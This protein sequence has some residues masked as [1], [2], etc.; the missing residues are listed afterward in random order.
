MSTC[1]S[2]RLA[3][4]VSSLDQLGAP[5]PPSSPELTVDQSNKS[6][7]FRRT[8]STFSTFSTFTPVHKPSSRSTT[9]QSAI[10]ALPASPS[11]ADLH[12]A[13]RV[14]QSHDH[15]G[16]VQ[17]QQEESGQNEQLLEWTLLARLVLA[18]Y[19][20]R[21]DELVRSAGEWEDEIDWWKRLDG[22]GRWAWDGIGG[23]FVQSK[24]SWHCSSFL[25]QGLT[26]SSPSAALPHRLV[27]ASVGLYQ[28][29]DTFSYRSLTPT[30]LL[31]SLFPTT[32]IPRS[33]QY[34]FNPKVVLRM[35]RL[36][37]RARIQELETGR[38]DRVKKL[39][40]VIVDAPWFGKAEG[41][42]DA[43]KLGKELG[44]IIALLQES[45]ET[46]G[47]RHVSLPAPDIQ[48]TSTPSSLF[49]HFENLLTTDPQ[50]HRLPS[51]LTRP[52]AP[53]RLWPLLVL[54]PFG[55]RALAGYLPALK[56][57]L[58]DAE[59]T[60]RG[61]WNGWVVEPLMGIVDTVRH[62][63]GEEGKGLSVVSKD[64]LKSDMDVRQA[65]SSRRILSNH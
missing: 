18:K 5:S 39:G 11:A 49:P 23:F 58:G 56:A 54:L 43:E 35:T 45:Q 38:D 19:G 30:H 62:G 47:E 24:S 15:N 59:E 50:D 37:V 60:A 55:I 32:P 64:G 51:Y 48:A 22:T 42:L 8:A 57:A 6:S 41:G 13:L 10:Q 7:L 29:R 27:G 16:Q 53:T 52:T 9:L 26:H 2:L 28:S 20:M 44:R 31:S 36:E 4:L 33:A 61:F 25:A 3:S 14:L 40:K 65:S 46:D 21:V 34:F 63:G 17:I 1:T 12:S